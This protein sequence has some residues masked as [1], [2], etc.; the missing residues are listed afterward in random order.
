MAVMAQPCLSSPTQAGA[1]A[2]HNT[3]LFLQQRPHQAQ[4]Q[5]A[6]QPWAQLTL[7]PAQALL[8]GRMLALLHLPQVTSIP[9]AELARD[10]EH[11]RCNISRPAE[12]ACLLLRPCLGG[13]A[14]MR[15]CVSLQVVFRRP[16]EEE[17]FL[18]CDRKACN[19]QSSCILQC[20]AKRY[21][22]SELHCTVALQVAPPIPPCSQALTPPFPE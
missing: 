4:Q 1:G 16:A 19:E 13:K 11:T 20:L 18:I 7:L 12:A 15:M 22:C 5:T 2:L 6:R 9:Q 17:Q 10:P 8:P 3:S 14:H 21:A